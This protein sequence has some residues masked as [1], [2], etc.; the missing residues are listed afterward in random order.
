MSNPG[1]GPYLRIS[2]PDKGV[3]LTLTLVTATATQLNHDA[4]FPIGVKIV[5]G[6]FVGRSAF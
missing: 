5:R 6:A 2:G 4:R 3:F 1:P